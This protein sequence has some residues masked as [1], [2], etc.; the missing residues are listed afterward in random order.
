VVRALDSAIAV[1]V[2]RS[3]KLSLVR[4]VDAVQSELFCPWLGF[5]GRERF[6]VHT[7][8]AADESISGAHRNSANIPAVPSPNMLSLMADTLPHEM[9]WTDLLKHFTK[10]TLSSHF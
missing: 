7:N 6:S 9:Q 1:P 4:L 8:K 5:A 3:F 2:V 10:R